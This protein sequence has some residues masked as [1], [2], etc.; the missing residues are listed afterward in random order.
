MFTQAKHREAT[1]SFN[2]KA[3]KDFAKDRK[4]NSFAPFA[5]SFAAFAFTSSS[6]LAWGFVDRGDY[7]VS[8]GRKD[9]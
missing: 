2:A 7:N 4:V 3:A 8:E 9:C 1:V 5:K 6:C